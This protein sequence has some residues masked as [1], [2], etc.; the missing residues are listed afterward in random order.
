MHPTSSSRAELVLDARCATGES[1][2]W[3]PAEES[4]YWTDIPRAVLH[5]WSARTGTRAQWTSPEMVACMAAWAGRPGRWIAGLETGLFALD[6]PQAG[7]ALA[8]ER[9]AG[10]AHA[11]PG[12]RFNDG[13]CDRQGRFVAGTMLMD[14]AAASPVGA[15]FRF[16][17]REL[18]AGSATDL[19]LGPLIVPNGIAFSP[20]GRTMY[21]SDSHPQVQ[22]IWAFDYDTATGTP[23]G[24][25][26]FV[27]MAPLPGRPDGAAIDVDGGYWICG[28]D[29]G[30]VHRFT[31][32]GRLDRSLAVPVKKP[33]MCAFGG[34]RLD[35]LFVTSIRPGAEADL[36]DQPLAGG[37]FALHPGTQGLPE[38][39]FDPAAE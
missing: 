35:T 12:M 8:A 3:R 7:G 25:R 18:A 14:M 5:R 27:D 32:D 19:G 36:A 23:H 38:P 37:V 16:G 30:L 1:P 4:L 34:P 39:E 6:L 28:N 21:L 9:L 17:G 22:K 20:D 10:V 13:R 26:L 2:V 33:A 24:R 31:P 11:S 15:V 29:A